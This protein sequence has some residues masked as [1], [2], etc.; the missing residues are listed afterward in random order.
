MSAIGI[1]NLPMSPAVVDLGLG[2]QLQ[3]QVEDQEL[4]RKKK[5]N[6][7]ASQATVLGGAAQ[8]L[9]GTGSATQ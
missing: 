1:K 7:M 9:F 3:T 8:A 5:L 2:A 6:Q 4:E